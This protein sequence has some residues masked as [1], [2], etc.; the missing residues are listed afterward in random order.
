MGLKLHIGGKQPH[1]DWKI[2]DIE[3]RP[4]VDFVGDAADLSQ[5]DSNS[6]EAIYASHVLEHFHHSLHNEL[7][8][9]LSEWHRVLKPGGKLYISVPDLQTLCWLYLNPNLLPIERIHLMSIFYGGHTN[10][11][12]VH[13]VGFDFDT[14]AMF[15]EEVGFEEYERLT[16]FSLFDDCSSMRILDTLISLNVAATKTLVSEEMEADNLEADASDE[17]APETTAVEG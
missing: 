13:R 8:Q 1:P 16:E 2:L 15:L 12:D 9:T 7:W 3:E 6:I 10:E 11:F 14:L 4:E 5:F 17:S